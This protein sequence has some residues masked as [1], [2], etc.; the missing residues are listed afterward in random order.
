MKEDIAQEIVIQ[1]NSQ[2][3]LYMVTTGD[4]IPTLYNEAINDQNKN[5]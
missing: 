2:T 1:N 4:N 5:K 3:I